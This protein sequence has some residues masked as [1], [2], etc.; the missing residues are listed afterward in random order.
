MEQ[1]NERF[2]NTV[3]ILNLFFSIMICL[4]HNNGY[5]FY[6]D[7]HLAYGVKRVI[8]IVHNGYLANIPV[9]LFIFLS[10]FLFYRNIDKNKIKDK[11]F[12]RVRSLVVPYVCWNFITGGVLLLMQSIP[13]IRS[14]MAVREMASFDLLSVIKGL[15]ITP[16]DG[17]LWTVLQLIIFVACAPLIYYL[18]KNK[19]IGV[20]VLIIYLLIGFT[21]W[22]IPFLIHGNGHLFTYVLGGYVGLH[23]FD[24]IK[25]MSWRPMHYILAGIVIIF[26]C[27]LY[28]YGIYNVVCQIAGYAALYIG[29]NFLAGYATQVSRK[30]YGLSFW[31]YA[32]HDWLEPCIMKLVQL[33]GLKGNMGALVST[34]IGAAVTIFICII[35][36][37]ICK[38][39]LP[40]LYMILSGGRG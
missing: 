27:V 18:L 9:P 6:D 14:K 16:Y 12:S 35:C 15:T 3:T 4:Y 26:L 31:I 7:G 10:G 11:M 29:A 17:V 2:W 1:K 23:F 13:F 37:R 24:S 22:N 30:C 33:T 38:K 8:D 40:K 19:Y 20:L 21:E 36:A 32:I 39:L 34:F 25:N 28:E 5:Y